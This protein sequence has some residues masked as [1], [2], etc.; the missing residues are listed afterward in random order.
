MAND[1]RPISPINGQPLPVGKPL[2]AGDSRA[3]ELQKKS[4]KSR[5][6]NANFAR[7]MVKA[8]EREIKAK[9]GTT[10][11]VAEALVLKQVELGLKGNQKSFELC[12]DTAGQ[13]PVEKVMIA[14]VDQAV[15]D[16]VEA[17]V[18]DDAGA[19]D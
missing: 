11:S 13:K 6:E 14:E 9:D 1:D 19:G 10:M 5:T 18:L 8:L 7:L 16:E 12:R 15:I 2:V 3:K 4:A 17:A